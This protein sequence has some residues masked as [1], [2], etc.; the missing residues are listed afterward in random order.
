MDPFIQPRQFVKSIWNHWKVHSQLNWLRG[1]V[2]TRDWTQ[3]HELPAGRRRKRERGG[4]MNRVVEWQPNIRETGRQTALGLLRRT[5][6]RGSLAA[7]AVTAIRTFDMLLNDDFPIKITRPPDKT[8]S[9]N[10]N[11]TLSPATVYC[12]AEGLKG[13]RDRHKFSC[14]MHS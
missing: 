4:R 9:S 8:V 3:D 7:T 10:W 12:R 14:F 6:P 5:W 13:S 11:Y 2:Q 1:K